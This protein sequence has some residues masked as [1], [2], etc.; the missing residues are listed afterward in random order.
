MSLFWGGGLC[1]SVRACAGGGGPCCQWGP[2][3][4]WS[5]VLGTPLLCLKYW[6]GARA[7]GGGGECGYYEN[8]R[9]AS[10]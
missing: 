8:R 9:P 10:M 2:L 5:S 3:C 4:S 7:R 1:R 6:V